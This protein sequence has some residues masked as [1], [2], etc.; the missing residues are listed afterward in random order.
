MTAILKKVGV[1]GALAMAVST[2]AGAQRG[3]NNSDHLMGSMTNASANGMFAP[4]KAGP[5]RGAV[6]SISAGVAAYVMN[7]LN[8]GSICSPLTGNFITGAPVTNLAALMNGSPSGVTSVTNALTNAGAPAGPVG[9]L[10]QSLNGLGNDPSFSRVVASSQA[11][12]ALV[13]NTDTP[14][15]AL[16][17]PQMLAIHAA[18]TALGGPANSFP[19][20]TQPP[21]PPAPAPPP[22]PPP[23]PAQR[24]T[25]PP[26]TPARREMLTM[27]GAHFAFDK[28]TLTQAAKDTLGQAVRLLKEHPE[29]NAEIQGHTD[30]VGTEVYNQALSE[31][32]ANSVKAY[33]VSQGISE[34]R[35]TTKGFGESQPTADNRT[36]E[37]RAENRRVIIIEIP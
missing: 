18:L 9:K 10:V 31:R 13:A 4:G 2:A 35:I 1:M 34:G 12:N 33:L 29:A 11:F 17:D 7:A 16:N 22:P 23:P 30:F 6:G 32:R 20:C 14:N 37:G 27:R 19:S 21:P 15:S 36:A 24:P 3:F 28:S 25:P 26:P 8:A 5:N